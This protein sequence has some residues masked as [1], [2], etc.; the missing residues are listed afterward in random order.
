[1]VS[2]R[3]TAAI[4]AVFALLLVSVSLSAQ[5]MRP[6]R[7]FNANEDGNYVAQAL[8]LLL[9]ENGN[10]SL[11]NLSTEKLS[12]ALGV[13]SVAR[14]QQAYVRRSEIS[15]L[16]MP[17]AGQ[18][19]N[20]SPGAGAL[21]LGGHLATVA[22]T[23]VGAYFLL[24]SNLQFGSINY[25]TD[26][27]TNIHNAWMGHSFVDYLPSAAVLAGGMIVDHLIRHFAAENAGDLARTNIKNKKVTFQ[28]EPFLLTHGP[29]G[30]GMGFGWRMRF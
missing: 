23:L 24:P 1:M 11:S 3:K 20:H 2:F 28:P 27:F 10:T 9:S 13:I 30:F 18:F 17:G 16:I 19:M 14:Q 6:K 4:G 12:K 25:F 15:S 21:F 8:Q 22:G 29:H 5:T 26:S 7:A